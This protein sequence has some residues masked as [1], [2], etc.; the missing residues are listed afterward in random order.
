MYYSAS[1]SNGCLHTLHHP[2]E[3]SGLIHLSKNCLTCQHPSIFPALDSFP[4][5][6]SMI[7]ANVCARMYGG[8][9]ARGGVGQ[10]YGTPNSLSHR[11]KHDMQTEGFLTN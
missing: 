5:S 11:H 4:L 10:I 8:G 6:L 7:H 3:K 1:Q 2:A 9:R